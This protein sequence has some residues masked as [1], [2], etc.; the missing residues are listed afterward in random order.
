MPLHLAIGGSL[1][2][3]MLTVDSDDQGW[4]ALLFSREVA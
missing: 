2:N 4:A 3:P 1:V